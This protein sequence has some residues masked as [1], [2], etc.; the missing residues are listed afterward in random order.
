MG[1]NASREDWL[2][3]AK[4]YLE[5]RA[6]TSS[7]EIY[8]QVHN[9]IRRI[10]ELRRYLKNHGE[11][12]EAFFDEAKRSRAPVPQYIQICAPD[13]SVATN[14]K[15]PEPQCQAAVSVPRE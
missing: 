13:G 2:A 11:R 3:W 7:S 1:K 5:E 9:K 8:I 12:E 6:S 14:T 10:Q 4:L 15:P